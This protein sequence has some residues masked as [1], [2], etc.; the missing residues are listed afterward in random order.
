MPRKRTP[1]DLRSLARSYTRKSVKVLAGIMMQEKAPEAARVAAS[2]E[3][4]DRGWGKPAQSHTGPDG[5]GP[6]QFGKIEVVIRHP[7]PR[8]L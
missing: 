6:I 8:N 2:K 4:L 7:D 3:L 1:A 5:E